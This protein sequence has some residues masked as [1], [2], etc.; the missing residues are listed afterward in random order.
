MERKQKDKTSTPLENQTDST[1]QRLENLSDNE[2]EQIESRIIKRIAR[3]YSSAAHSADM[4]HDRNSSV[5]STRVGGKRSDAH[6]RSGRTDSKGISQSLFD[7][8]PHDKDPHD[9]DP[10]N[11]DRNNFDRNNFDRH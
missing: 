5:V 3:Q 2:I 7:K 10:G 8:D 1:N 11:F 9:K 4:L 6:E